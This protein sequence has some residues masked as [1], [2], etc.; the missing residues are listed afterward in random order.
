[1][2]WQR[3]QNKMGRRVQRGFA[4]ISAIFILVVMV[5]LGG[6]ILSVSTNQQIG[7]ALDVQGA[8]A[9][10]AARSGIE[11]GLYRQFRDNN[12]AGAASFVPAAPTLAAFTVTVTCTQALDANGAAASF[13]VRATACNQPD[14]GACPNTTDPGPFYVERRLDVSF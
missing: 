10:E 6:F 9:Y 3:L 11:W 5:A 1:M 12:C 14:G 2:N 4:V 8:R 7:S 13:V